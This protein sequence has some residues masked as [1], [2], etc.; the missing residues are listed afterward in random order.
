MFLMHWRVIPNSSMHRHKF[1]VDSGENV[2]RNAM[3]P[4]SN[5]STYIYILTLAQ[6]AD[7]E[8]NCCHDMVITGTHS[9]KSLNVNSVD[10][11]N[12]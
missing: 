3:Q 9:G 4:L 7:Q 5:V 6:E 8:E 11:C 1:S 2:F 12:S 10:S